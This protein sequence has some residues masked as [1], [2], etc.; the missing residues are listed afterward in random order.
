MGIVIKEFYRPPADVAALAKV[1]PVSQ[2]KFS[3]ALLKLRYDKMD[4]AT[5]IRTEKTL[6]ALRENRYWK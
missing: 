2:Q 6:L 1:Y 3:E 5:Q 4:D